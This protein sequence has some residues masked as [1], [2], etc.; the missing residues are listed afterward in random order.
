M[1]NV[2]NIFLK[3][4]RKEKKIIAVNHHL[5]KFRT[6]SPIFHVPLLTQPELA[7]DLVS[8]TTSL[9]SLIS[10]ERTIGPASMAAKTSLCNQPNRC[11]SLLSGFIA[12]T[13]P[14]V[15]SDPPHE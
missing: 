3:E 13:G 10:A 2:V 4:R 5:E 7:V 15:Q 8:I 14:E 1:F 12:L 6:L 9:F 11:T